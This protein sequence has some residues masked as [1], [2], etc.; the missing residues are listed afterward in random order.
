MQTRLS[1]ELAL[2]LAGV[3]VC[4]LHASTDCN[5]REAGGTCH[6]MAIEK[7]RHALFCTIA[8]GVWIVLVC[9]RLKV[10]NHSVYIVFI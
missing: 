6:S 2:V 4:S 1:L 5:S 9:C 7:V 3:L 8:E 10:I